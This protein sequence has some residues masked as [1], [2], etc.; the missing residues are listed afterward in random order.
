MQQKHA[1]TN[2]AV[3]AV[4]PFCAVSFL[5]FLLGDVSTFIISPILSKIQ[6]SAAL[7]KF[8]PPAPTTMLCS[9]QPKK[10]Y[11]GRCRNRDGIKRIGSV[12][13][14]GRAPWFLLVDIAVKAL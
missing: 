12:L 1:Q 11:K 3:L 4:L 2:C 9:K 14:I 6:K 5:V 7:Q 13:R 10:T 8:V